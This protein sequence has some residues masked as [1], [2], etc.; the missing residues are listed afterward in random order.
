MF[1][2]GIKA[3]TNTHFHPV[4]RHYCIRQPYSG[5]WGLE[6]SNCKY[7]LESLFFC[8]SG[9]HSE[10][11]SVKPIKFFQREQNQSLFLSGNRSFSRNHSV[12]FFQR[13]SHMK[14][15]ALVCLLNFSRQGLFST[16]ALS[17]HP[18]PKLCFFLPKRERRGGE[19]PL[20]KWNI[21]STE[22]GFVKPEGTLNSD[23]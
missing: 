16:F 14:N 4:P 22:T 7:E 12:Q 19:N 23:P 3:H 8:F 1:P 15:A 6:R 9:Y 10:K 13:N 20:W 18:L 11:Y 5:A 17:L 2:L 21:T